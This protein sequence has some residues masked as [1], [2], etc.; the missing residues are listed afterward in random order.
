MI[1]GNIE[2]RYLVDTNRPYAQ[3]LEERDGDGNLLV[4]YVYGHDLISQTRG[5][6]TSYYHYDG[7]GS[8]RA[9]SSSAGIVT[10]SYTYDAFG[11]LLDQNGFT[12]NSPSP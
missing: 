2:I 9:L 7:L 11:N 4:R 8:T 1:N 5:N 10:D 3:V 12:T 6:V